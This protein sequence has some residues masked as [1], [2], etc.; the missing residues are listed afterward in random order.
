MDKSATI[1]ITKMT[2]DNFQKKK[3]NRGET[4]SEGNVLMSSGII[5]IIC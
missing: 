3:N 4:K 5:E 2:Q 1:L